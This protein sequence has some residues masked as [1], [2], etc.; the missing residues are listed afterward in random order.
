MNY[1]IEMGL[2]AMI[3]MPTV[4][5]INLGVRKLIGGGGGVRL[6]AGSKAIP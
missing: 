2:N 3:Y 6:Q 5:N 1:A 4:I